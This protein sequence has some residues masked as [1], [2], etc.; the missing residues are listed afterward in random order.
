MPAVSTPVNPLRSV[1]TDPR[2]PGPNGRPE[3]QAQTG[4]GL[5]LD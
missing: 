4:L 5:R 2:Q 1:Q 3:R